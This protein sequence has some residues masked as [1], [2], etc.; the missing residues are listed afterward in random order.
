MSLFNLF[1][2]KQSDPD[3][4]VLTQLRKA[5]S[6]LAKP[7]PVEFF[8]YFPSEAL[9]NKA[10]AQIRSSGFHVEV[11]PGAQGSGWLCLATKQ[12]EPELQSLQQIRAE[13]TTLANSLGGEYD[14]WGT[15]VVN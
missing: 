15:P 8:L 5:G 9:G 4:A 7:H 10:A 13:F 2:R 3:Q 1:R 14:G 12:I 11:K 6:K